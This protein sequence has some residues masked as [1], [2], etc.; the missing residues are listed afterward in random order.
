MFHTI[1]SHKARPTSFP[2]QPTHKYV[3]LHFAIQKLWSE[4]H[5]ERA[6]V[7]NQGGFAH[8][9]LSLTY[10]FSLAKL[11]THLMFHTCTGMR[12][13]ILRSYSWMTQDLFDNF[14]RPEWRP[15]LFTISM[16]HSIVQV[17][18]CN[19]WGSTYL[20]LG[21]SQAWAKQTWAPSRRQTVKP[22][23]VNCWPSRAQRLLDCSVAPGR[24]STNSRQ[25]SAH[26]R[27]VTADDHRSPSVDNPPVD[28]KRCLDFGTVD[29]I[30]RCSRTDR[31][32]VFNRKHFRGFLVQKCP[33]VQGT[34]RDGPHRR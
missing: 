30:G 23:P 27:R 20:G 26:C 29:Y 12:A 9:P 11:T 31:D 5:T 16:L 18:L 7:R 17:L 10:P 15:M 24:L 19:A 3:I 22:F 4:N 14:R 34:T 2:L 1:D 13:G 21:R 8:V 33:A 6:D 25:P 28:C 32:L